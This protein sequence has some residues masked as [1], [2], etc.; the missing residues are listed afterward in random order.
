MK[1]VDFFAADK[2]M[3]ER[4][5]DFMQKKVWGIT[6]R[7]RIKREITDLEGKIANLEKLRGSIFDEVDADGNNKIDIQKEEYITLSEKKQ[8]ELEDQIEAE[9]TFAYSDFDNEFY[10]AYKKAEKNSDIVGAIATWFRHYNLDVVDAV[11]VTNIMDAIAG[12]RR[13]SAGALIR[14]GA[15]K[16]NADKRTKNDVVLLFYGELAE[17]MLQ[18][19]TLKATAI[20][21]DVREFYAPKKKAAKKNTK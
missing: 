11:I 6:L 4:V 20:P 18:A 10:K 14:S 15:T 8:K 1:K 9:A 13:N 5:A 16:F 7:S 21:E 2:T 17:A 19:G 3:S 12:K